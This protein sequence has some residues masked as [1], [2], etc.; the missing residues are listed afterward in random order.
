[1]PQTLNEWAERDEIN[2]GVRVST[3]TTELQRLN[4]FE[5]DSKELRKANEILKRASAF[6]SKLRVHLF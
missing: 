6:L 2:T 1:M 4:E 5:G 3:T